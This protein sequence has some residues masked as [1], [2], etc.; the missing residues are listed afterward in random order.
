MLL[1]SGLRAALLQAAAAA[2]PNE[3]CGLLGGTGAE[4]SAFIPCRNVLESPTRYAIAPEEVL[5][6]LKRLRAA[7]LELRAIFHSHPLGPARPSATDIRE[8]AYPGA[9]HLIVG[10]LPEP[11]LRGF[12][13]EGD[14]VSEETLVPTP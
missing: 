7:D 14:E 13:I 8:A 3:A 2:L 4:L 10:F 5:V 1:P 6:A 9:L 12:S 11:E